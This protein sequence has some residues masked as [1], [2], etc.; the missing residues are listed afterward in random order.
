MP[1]SSQDCKCRADRRITGGEGLLRCEIS[2][3][4]TAASGQE[5]TIPQVPLCQLR[6]AADMPRA[7]PTAGMCQST[8]SLLDSCEVRPV[9][10]H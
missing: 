3:L 8:K 7:W 9:L 10:S 2:T 1:A 6:P 4:L 5:A